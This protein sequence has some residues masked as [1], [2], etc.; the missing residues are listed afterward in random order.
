MYMKTHIDLNEQ[1]LKQ[2]LL[3]GH[4]STKKEAVHAAMIEYVKFLKRQNLL[5]LQGKMHWE[6]N[7]N[8]LRKHRNKML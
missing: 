6:G 1:M 2:I 3:L 4:F 8:Q 7:L 5:K